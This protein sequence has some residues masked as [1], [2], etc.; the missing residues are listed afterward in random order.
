MV[1]LTES[2]NSSVQLLRL[3]LT[4]VFVFNFYCWQAFCICVSCLDG[5]IADRKGYEYLRKFTN[6]ATA[7][8]AESE[9]VG[10]EIAQNGVQVF[11][12][13]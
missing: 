8:A 12:V 9:V 2:L 11:L 13:F 10:G 4:C 6:G 5:K 3:I 1:T 7:E